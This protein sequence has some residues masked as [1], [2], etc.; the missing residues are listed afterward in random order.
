MQKIL[1]Y[2]TF[3]L[4]FFSAGCKKF[5][6]K[7]PDNRAALNTPEQVSQ[8]LGTAYPQENYMAF[9]ESISDNVTD[10]G[11]GVQEKPI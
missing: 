8:L 6:E 2:T 9:C 4:L 7:N 1:S 11:T 10:K 5:L 3:A